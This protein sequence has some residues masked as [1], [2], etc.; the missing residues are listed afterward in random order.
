MGSARARRVGTAR[1]FREGQ[2]EQPLLRLHPWSC[3]AAAPDARARACARAETRVLSVGG[4][5][6]NPERWHAPMPATSSACAGTHTLAWF[7]THKAV[8]DCTER[9]E[10]TRPRA[11]RRA[12]MARAGTF[13]ITRSS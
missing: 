5:V 8:R 3:L 13:L 2:R 10:S 1:A 6:V 12:A 7:C 11:L 9:G 4:A